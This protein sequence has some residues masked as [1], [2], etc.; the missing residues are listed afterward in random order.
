VLFADMRGFST[1]SDKIR[2]PEKLVRMVNVYFDHMTDAIIKNEGTLDKFVGDEVMAFFGAPMPHA[3]HA[4][5]AVRA[6]LEMQKQMNDVRRVLA[7][8]EGIKDVAIGI[9]IN[10]G[11]MV[12]GNIGCERKYDYTV[13]GHAVNTGA[14]LCGKADRHQIVISDATYQLVKNRFNCRSIGEMNVK[15][16][17]AAVTVYEVLGEK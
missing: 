5:H 16:I 9:G 11:D 4:E 10:T 2:D 8:Q 1:I 15:G 6:A 14:R 12:V 13:L 7:R 3:D 17:A